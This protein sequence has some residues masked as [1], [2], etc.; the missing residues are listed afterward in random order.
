[1][2]LEFHK[3]CDHQ[4]ATTCVNTYII[5]FCCTFT[6]SQA[7]SKLVSPPSSVPERFSHLSTL[8]SLSEQSTAI[9]KVPLPTGTGK[10]SHPILPPTTSPPVQQQK[11]Y[12]AIKNY[13][14]DKE[15]YVHLIAGESVEV[16]DKS[17]PEQWVIATVGN[18]TRPSEEGHV[19]AGLLSAEYI[20]VRYDS[21]QDRCCSSSS[22][23]EQG[24]VDRQASKQDDEPPPLPPNHPNHDDDT[25]QSPSGGHDTSE[26]E[27]GMADPSSH[28]ENA[29]L[30]ENPQTED[31]PTEGENKGEDE[32]QPLP[33]NHDN[34]SQGNSSEV[35]KSSDVSG[36]VMDSHHDDT[37]ST[38]TEGE[39]M[40]QPMEESQEVC[41]SVCYCIFH[42]YY[43]WLH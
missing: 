27:T 2:I 42:V 7:T 15:G 36:G 4:Y 31:L 21:L 29:P 28:T 3:S 34:S 25:V 43:D 40:K 11:V 14:P 37:S 9:P 23:N 13:H 12:F 8:S 24:G 32:R 1:M 18:E 6:A 38:N 17:N 26:K 16:L 41:L 30:T 10:I 35:V 20:P 22:E 39:M 5:Y 19:P 33:S